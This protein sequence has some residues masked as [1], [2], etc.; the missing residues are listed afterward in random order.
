MSSEQLKVLRIFNK[1]FLYKLFERDNA[2][3]FGEYEKLNSLIR[4]KFIC[5]CG[6]QNEKV[7]IKIADKG[8]AF[9]EECTKINT[10]I[11][12]EKKNMEKYGTK[13]PLQNKDILKKLQ[14]TNMKKYGAKNPLQNKDV[15]LRMKET[16]IKK[17][18]TTCSLRGKETIKKT[19]ETTL[20]KF[21]TTH[22]SKSKEV[23]KKVEETNRK[24][25]GGKAPASSKEVQKKMKE[26]SLK[27]H[28]SE[29]YTQTEEYKQK[30]E[31]TNL[32]RYG[33]KHSSQNLEVME[34]TQKSSK[35]YK[36]YI[37][38]SGKIIRVQGY[39]PWAL[40]ELVK[41]Y[42]EEDILTVRSDVPQIK[43]EIEEK[44]KMYFPDIFIKSEN[45]IIEVKS[46]WT[47]KCK[48]DNVQFKA[49]A[50]KKLGYNYEIWIYDYK[51]NKTTVL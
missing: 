28:G 15:S 51:K 10:R 2:K 4:I 19:L 25:Y 33:T 50:C 11:K 40:D 36:D 45:K 23:M 32:K 21:G 35:R 31:E 12:I 27:R 37:L 46:T 24:K 1:E 44:E 6:I 16:N 39:E 49:N 5:N 14:D 13:T 9:C 7:F 17:Y 30:S 42:K 8:G 29:F 48:E 47:Y 20:K 34:K 38:P 18:G 3:P 41:I 43:Y 22:T 26:T